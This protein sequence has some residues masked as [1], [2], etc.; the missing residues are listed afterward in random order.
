MPFEPV[1]VAVINFNGEDVLG[2]QLAVRQQPAIRAKRQAAAVEHQ[3]VIA[4]HGI[5]IKQR[6]PG[7]G[8]QPGEHL[9]AQGGLAE[10]PR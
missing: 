3:L 5:A 9:M 8:R 1:T 2:E 10:V 6:P 4:A 7:L